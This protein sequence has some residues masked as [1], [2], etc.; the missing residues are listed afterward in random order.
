MISEALIHNSAL[1]P[2]QAALQW[3]AETFPDRWGSTGPHFSKWQNLPGNLAGRFKLEGGAN[4]YHIVWA[5]EETSI[6]DDG[7]R[8]GGYL[9]S[10]EQEGDR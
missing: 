6:G 8:V 9:I 4:W 10:R 7:T 2:K 3:A 1:T 5:R